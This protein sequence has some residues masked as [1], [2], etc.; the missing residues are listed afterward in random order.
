MKA[1]D[2]YQLNSDRVLHTQ[3]N[4]MLPNFVK[5]I[6]YWFCRILFKIYCPLSVNGIEHLPPS[7][8]I[9]CSNHCS[10]MDSV[11]LMLST[12]LSFNNFGM[13]AAKDY[14]FKKNKSQ[15][16]N[17]ILNL[18][19]INRKCTSQ[20]LLENIS[21]CQSFTKRNRNLIIYPEGT[22][23]LSG[24]MGQ[25]KR[26][27]AL[28]ATELEIPIIPVHIQG[29]FEA[30]PKGKF[31]PKPKRISVMIGEALYSQSSKNKSKREHYTLLTQQ[32]RAS[33]DNLKERH[34]AK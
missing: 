12:Q 24:E 29:T 23:S 30:M 32:L 7:P 9:I 18:I 20:S 3:N 31:F 13:I 33:I 16:F 27:L 15:F 2:H 11:V 6:F 17:S 4:R 5:T 1:F 22:R 34:Y 21:I 28:I 25:F 10:H 8:F 14:F 26:G 19:P